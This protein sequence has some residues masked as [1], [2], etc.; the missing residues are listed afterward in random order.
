MWLVWRIIAALIVFAVLGFFL[1]APGYVER[2]QNPVTDHAPW[3]VSPAAASWSP[4]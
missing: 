4:T 2:A 1:F 3:P